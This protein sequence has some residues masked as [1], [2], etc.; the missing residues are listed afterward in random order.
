[1]TQ[2]LEAFDCVA[3]ARRVGARAAE[4]SAEVDRDGAFPT[5]DITELHREGL[6]LAPFPRSFGGEDL[7]RGSPDRLRDTLAVIG[8]GSLALG[9]LY[10]GHVNAIS[11]VARYGTAA[12]IERMLEE[13]LAGRP[14]GVWMAGEPLRLERHGDD[15]FALSGLKILCSG[16]GHFRRPLVAAM[17]DGGTVMVIP[18]VGDERAD[19]SG[20]V[21]HGMR[22]TASGAVTFDDIVVGRDEIVG[23]PGDY[24]R[25]PYFR[26]GAWRVIAVQLGGVEAILRHYKAQLGDSPHRDHPLQLARLGEALIA[27]ETA[28]LWVRQAS[29]AAEGPFDDPEAIDATVDL[30]RNAF[31]AAALRVI[32]LA[33]K[34]IGLK[35]FLR[36]NPIERIAR[37]L[38]TYL[39]QPGLDLSLLSA[40]AFHLRPAAC[41]PKP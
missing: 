2:N 22:A 27:C 12:N 28:R 29:V 14:S 4:R 7:G 13:A 24:L 34:A 6:L 10:E 17:I 30:A 33:Q 1:M 23:A 18:K 21:A 41:E 38:S 37:D 9:R 32:A 35:A 5:V 20:W 31:E 36:P 25:S 8:G 15:R 16:A 40:A 19:T 11:L 3:A 26:G 39:R